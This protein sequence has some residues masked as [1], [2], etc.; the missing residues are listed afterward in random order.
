[1]TLQSMETI[2]KGT[3]KRRVATS[4]LIGKFRSKSD[5]VKYLSENRKYSWTR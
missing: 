5:F 2:S 1:M 3:K 4:E